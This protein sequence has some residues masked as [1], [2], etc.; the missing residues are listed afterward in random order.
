MYDYPDGKLATPLVE[1][2]DSAGEETEARDVA[3][4]PDVYFVQVRIKA[5]EAST[6][7]L[8]RG[9]Q[10][11][12]DTGALEAASSSEVS[13]GDLGEVWESPLFPANQR[14][15]VL[16]FLATAGSARVEVLRLVR[17]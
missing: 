10:T 8:W 13:L 14:P 7:V 12:T 9:A 5:L 2:V 17:Q 4:G 6:V 15:P 1:T 11:S 3:L 16:R